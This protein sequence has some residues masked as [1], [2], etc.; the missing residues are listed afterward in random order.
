MKAM[1]KNIKLFQ[2]YALAVIALSSCTGT[3]RLAKA[4]RSLPKLE[5]Y[6]QVHEI[7]FFD[8]RKDVSDQEMNLPFVSTPRS[9]NK[10][11]PALTAE[12]KHLLETIIR[13][14]TLGSGLPVKAVITVEEAYKE[15]SAT[16][17]SEKERGFAKMKV[18]LYGL[19]T[20]QLIAEGN[21]SGD[22]FLQSIDATPRKMEKVYQLALRNVVYECL[23]G[24]N[25]Q[26]LNKSNHQ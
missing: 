24:M 7:V 5:R 20:N 8:Q 9:Y 12:H 3:M 6:F 17:A 16:M 18:A 10:H 14:N 13:E 25:Q 2:V 19:E 26:S 4:E 11:I 15:F 21:A 23:K 1:K 22:F